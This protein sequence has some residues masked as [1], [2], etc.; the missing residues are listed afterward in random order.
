MDSKAQI[1]FEDFKIPLVR[2]NIA[3]Y[4]IQNNTYTGECTRRDLPW[5]QRFQRE[6]PERVEILDEL[7]QS[8]HSPQEA[9]ILC[10]EPFYE[11]YKVMLAYDEVLSNQE[12]LK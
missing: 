7:V 11:V 8:F 10:P 12:L 5:F 3:T 6:Y 9:I 1:V 4:F 2:G